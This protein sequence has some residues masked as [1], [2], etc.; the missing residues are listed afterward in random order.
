MASPRTLACTLLVPRALLPLVRRRLR[1]GGANALLMRLCSGRP[2]EQWSR[3]RPTAAYQDKGQELIRVHVRVGPQVWVA[4]GLRARL[5]G[6]SR[7]LAFVLMILARGSNYRDT[8]ETWL[9]TAMRQLDRVLKGAVL[10]LEQWV[11]NDGR[12]PT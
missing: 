2:P 7:C 12:P 11:R 5:M 6:V 10:A 4:F 8:T 3:I 9:R 1:D